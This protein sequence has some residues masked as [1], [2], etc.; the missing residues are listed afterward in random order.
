MLGHLG[1]HWGGGVTK[2]LWMKFAEIYEDNII[3]Y[4]GVHGS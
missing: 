2:G 1:V 3:P 4:W